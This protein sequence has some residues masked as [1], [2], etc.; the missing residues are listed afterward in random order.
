MAGRR[1]GLGSEVRRPVAVARLQGRH[2]DGQ[3]VC[4]SVGGGR[5]ALIK[6]PRYGPSPTT[7]KSQLEARN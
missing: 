1:A 6:S 7:K 4:V 2:G 5:S 3:C